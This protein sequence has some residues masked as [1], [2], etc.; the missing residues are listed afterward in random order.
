LPIVNFIATLDFP[1]M[2]YNVFVYGLL[3][4]LSTKVS[5]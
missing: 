3:R 4:D 1:Q 5:K 2:H